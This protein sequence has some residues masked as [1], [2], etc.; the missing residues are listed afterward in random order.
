MKQVY[1]LSKSNLSLSKAEVLSLLDAEEYDQFDNVLIA[2]NK[3][4]MK[5]EKRLGQTH[6]IYRFLFKCKKKSLINTIEKYDWEKIYKKNFCVRVHDTAEFTEKDLA[7]YIYRKIR[8]PKVNLDNPKTKIEFFFRDNAVVCGLLL[9]DVDKSFCKRK[10]HLRP[11]LHP[12]SMHPGLARTLI[13]LTG[14][15]KGTIL[16]PFCGSGG[17]LIEAGL[18]GFKTIGYDIDEEQIKRAKKNTYFYKI[19]NCRLEKKDALNLNIKPDAVVTDFPYGKGSK[20]KNLKGLYESFLKR[21]YTKTNVCV[22]ML[23]KFISYKKI[24]SKTNW[25][26][27]NKFEIYVHKSLT[28]IILKLT[29]N[30]SH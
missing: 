10:A 4:K 29:K 27:K 16:D 7:G 1:L 20:G 12:T 23:P 9:S 19:K 2:E 8:N 22:V 24:I 26:I 21:A 15:E 30:L 14:L 3:K 17:I 13:N 6:S 18:M 5:L 25:K 11:S 28:R